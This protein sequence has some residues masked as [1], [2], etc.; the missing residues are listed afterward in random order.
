MYVSQVVVRGR[1]DVAAQLASLADARPGWVLAF[2]PPERLRDVARVLDA[3]FPDAI[4]TGCTTAG[5]ISAAG[6][7]GDT[8]VVT[9]VRF[10][11][12]PL[13]QASTTLSGMAD[14]HA[15]GVRLG[16][17]LPTEGLRAVLLIGQG[18][19]INGSALIR[20]LV[21]VIG[22]GIAVT[23]GLAGDEGAFRET[24]VLDRDG[25]CNETI[26]CLGFY[27]E[28][29]RYSHGS[30]GGWMPF[31]PMR[32]VTRADGNV[33]LELD[34]QPALETYKRYLGE[35]ARDLPGA[36]LLFPLAMVGGDHDEAGL[37]RTVLGVDE[38]QGSL[39]LAGELN[40][41]G[42]VRLMHASTDALVGGAEVAA[43]AAL[44]GQAGA[45][46]ALVLLVSCVGRKLLMG[47][48]VDEEV[49]AVADVFGSNAVL[50]G[51][52]SYGEISPRAIDR[53][54]RLHNQTMTITVFSE[55]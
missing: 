3:M 9:V 19:S 31:G 11:A 40:P 25:V 53:A 44:Q 49:E 12:V 55:A 45:S 24:F 36:A 35:H 43:G 37:I 28:G 46:P 10:R 22:P 39:T 42:Y 23:G 5:E 26:A 6:V 2:G 38:S 32:K 18:V 41:G 1:E 14:S 27:G 47:G 54:C 48:R 30:F 7:T 20:G 17:Q 16:V 4:R 33:L 15:A 29:L 21:E 51:F 52:Y 50:A 8:C 34:G 13:F